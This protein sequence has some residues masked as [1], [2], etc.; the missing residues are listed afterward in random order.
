MG[1]YSRLGEM[2]SGIG[3]CRAAR[4]LGDMATETRQSKGVSVAKSIPTSP[5]L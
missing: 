4:P 2:S 5:A 1:F 3:G